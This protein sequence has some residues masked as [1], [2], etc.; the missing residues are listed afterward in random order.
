MKGNLVKLITVSNQ[1][2]L[3][4]LLWLYYTAKLNILKKVKNDKCLVVDLARED[5]KSNEMEFFFPMVG[6]A[7]VRT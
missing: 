5:I 6:L 4:L 7:I 2:S 1:I 3:F